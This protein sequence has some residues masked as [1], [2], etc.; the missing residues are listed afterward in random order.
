MYSIN[1][2]TGAATLV[3]NLSNA[4]FTSLV[5]L[6]ARNG[7]LYGTDVGDASFDFSFGTINL[8]TGAYFPLNHQ[9]GS[10]N[11]HGLAYNPALDL[12]YTV[13]LDQSGFPLLSVTPDGVTI[14][15]IG[16]TNQFI[17]GLAFDSNNGVL[18]GVAQG[19]DLF[20]IDILTGAATL[21]GSSGIATG[22]PG[23]A[24]DTENDILFLNVGDD[25]SLYTLDI[26][27]GAA[28]LVGLNGPTADNGIDGLAFVP[29]ASAIPEPASLALLGL[30]GLGFFGLVYRRRNASLN[31]DTKGV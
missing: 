16:D 18:Y 10:V 2:T 3:T 30:G 29:T 5:G 31:M 26:A 23:L 25:G 11:W 8:T 22:R 19:G 14:S 9:G 6:E 7:V 20:A 1:P 4:A 27:T 24:Y 21:I 13:D 17:A 15:P 12:F 28:T